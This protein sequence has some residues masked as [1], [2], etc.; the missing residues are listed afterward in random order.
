M[1]SR[2]TY[3]HLGGLH[4]ECCRENVVLSLCTRYRMKTSYCEPMC[5]RHS[6]MF[7][8]RHSQYGRHAVKQGR[9]A[10]ADE[11]SP[12]LVHRILAQW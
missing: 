7:G 2:T 4:A 3:Q 8:G 1:P 9:C 5:H 11:P 12:M 6:A 10:V